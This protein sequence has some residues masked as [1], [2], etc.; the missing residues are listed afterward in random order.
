MWGQSPAQRL[1]LTGGRPPTLTP[2]RH[3]LVRIPVA[4][5][6]KFSLINEPVT[7]D[8]LAWAEK[9]GVVIAPGVVPAVVDGL[10][11]LGGKTVVASDQDIVSVPFKSAITLVPFAP[12]PFSGL[13]ADAWKGLSPEKKMAC[14][15]LKDKLDGTA[16]SR[17]SYIDVLPKT[18]TSTAN[19][20]SA[21]LDKLQVRR[22]NGPTGRP[23]DHTPRSPHAGDLQT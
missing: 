5:A 20:T 19:W 2:H 4:R 1:S 21:E 17:K 13:S 7:N 3:G 11:G 16:S 10:R 9:E 14:L 12:S 8:F 15:L 22:V 6:S 23:T 18:Y